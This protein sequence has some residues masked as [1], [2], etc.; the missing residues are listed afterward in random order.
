[1]TWNAALSAS[2]GSNS[3]VS[4]FNTSVNVNGRGG[5]PL[6][7]FSWPDLASSMRKF[8]PQPILQ[9]AIRV[10]TIFLIV[11][12]GVMPLKRKLLLQTGQ[13]LVFFS[14]S[15]FV[16]HTRQKLCSQE[17]ICTGKDTILWHNLHLH[18][19]SWVLMEASSF[20]VGSKI[21]SSNGVFS[22]NRTVCVLVHLEK[23]AN[24]A[25]RPGL[26]LANLFS[27]PSQLFAYLAHWTVTIWM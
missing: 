22:F 21:F 17:T 8:R 18:R 20:N 10:P 13:R 11:T 12:D 27:W 5:G 16:T 25:G 6:H 15:S 23:G 3:F 24:S 19:S 7:V 1:M 14:S 4:T 26:R 2:F 9:L